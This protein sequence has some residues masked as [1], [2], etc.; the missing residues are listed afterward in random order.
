MSYS[1]TL[2]INSSGEDYLDKDITG[3]AT[4]SC[5]FKSPIDIERP[6]I[7]I[8][9]GSAYDTYNYCY[10]PEFN[11][12]YFM[13]PVA[14]N[15]QTLTFECESDPLMSFKTEIRACPAVVARNPWHFDLY[16]P[17][18]KLPIE[19]RTASATVKFPNNHFSGDHNCYILT[20]LGSGFQL[21][22]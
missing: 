5:D 9:G 7:Y 4:V 16:L 1:V 6:T 8:S 20:T 19:T 22:P 18:S 11:R 3:G 14:G 10:I 12:Y 15:G 2:Y 13:K 17:D 21:T